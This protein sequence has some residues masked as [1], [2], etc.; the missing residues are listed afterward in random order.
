MALVIRLI[1]TWRSLRSSARTVPAGLAQTQRDAP[2]SRQRA[3]QFDDVG[4]DIGQVHLGEVDGEGAGL[5]LRDVEHV[6][7]QRRDV[8]GRA[9]DVSEGRFTPLRRQVHSAQ[10]FGEPGDG[11]ERSAQLMTE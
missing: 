2:F 10:Q 5:D 11:L 1:T 6:I 9:L 7:D 8:R 3:E 4:Q